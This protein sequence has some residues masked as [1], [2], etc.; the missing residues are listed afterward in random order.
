[1]ANPLPAP[2]A[3]PGRTCTGR[4]ATWEVAWPA[5]CAAP[6]SPS[7][8]LNRS[9]GSTD[10]TRLLGST[11]SEP[12]VAGEGGAE[13]A[14]ESGAAAGAGKPWSG[15][16]ESSGATSG[17]SV[18]MVAVTVV[19]V[20]EE[21]ERAGEAG[22]TLPLVGVSCCADGGGAGSSGAGVGVSVRGGGEERENPQGAARAS[23]Q[24]HGCSP[25]PMGAFGPPRPHL[26]GAHHCRSGPDG[27]AGLLPRRLQAPRWVVRG[28]RRRSSGR[29]ER[30]GR[31]LAR[32]ARGER[33]PRF[34]RLLGLLFFALQAQHPRH[35]L[36]RP[37]LAGR[38]CAGGELFL[39]SG[40]LARD[41]RAEAGEAGQF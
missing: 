31:A 4:A 29:A 40:Q 36:E 15:A 13:G 19:A 12:G 32:G 2:P 26:G 9:M 30:G 33:L 8:C 37:R 25:P 7:S 28:R 10:P 17:T 27:R 38:H 5:R 18:V 20:T 3:A 41:R 11:I 34:R 1:M 16:R 22:A 35:G 21:C 6:M 39:N 24:I 14:G 23:M